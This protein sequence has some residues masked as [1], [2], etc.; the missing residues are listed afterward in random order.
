MNRDRFRGAVREMAGE[1][2]DA[3]GG[4]AGDARLQARGKFDRAAGSMQENY[5]VIMQD[6]HDF[7]DRLRLRTREQPLV[8]LL[9]AAA[10]GYLIGRV[11]RWL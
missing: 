9:A 2:E 4:L 7:T 5:G 10:L 8:A 3:V 6:V 1:A 11:G